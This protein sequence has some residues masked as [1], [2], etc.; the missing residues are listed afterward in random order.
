LAQVL[1]KCAL[2]DSLLSCLQSVVIAGV[3][4]LNVFCARYAFTQH[5][6]FRI[7]WGNPWRFESSYPHYTVTTALTHTTPNIMHLP[8]GAGMAESMAEQARIAGWNGMFWGVITGS[9]QRGRLG[10]LLPGENSK[11]IV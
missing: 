5:M 6:G 7:Q 4:L 2:N 1:G 11:W 9:G 10:A 3:M 8:K